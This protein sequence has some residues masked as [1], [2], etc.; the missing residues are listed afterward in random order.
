MSMRGSN[1]TF[2]SVQMLYYKCDKVDFERG[3]SDIDISRLD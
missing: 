1:F 2:D 3:G